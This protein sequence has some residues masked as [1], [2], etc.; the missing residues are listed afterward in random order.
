MMIMQK[1]SKRGRLITSLVVAVL[2]LG[3]L[4]FLITKL[5]FSGLS[6]PSHAPAFVGNSKL[7]TGTEIVATLD[8]PLTSGKSTIWCASFVAAWKMIESDLAGEPVSLNGS[9][10]VV[11]LLNAAVD[12]KTYVP[13]DTLYSA[14]GW[15][16]KGIIDKIIKGV[17]VFK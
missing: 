3:L 7:L 11:N 1:M 14:A 15:N 5:F 12:P 8:A 4:F 6:A 9:P 2:L 10:P 16:D 17:D 13:K